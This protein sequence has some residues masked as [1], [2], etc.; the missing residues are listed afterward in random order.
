M[1]FYKKYCQADDIIKNGHG[2]A[3]DSKR[4]IKP[5]SAILQAMESYENTYSKRNHQ[6]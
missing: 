1:D 5:K 4:T 3:Y 6:T 2:S